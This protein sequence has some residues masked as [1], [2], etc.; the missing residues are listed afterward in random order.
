MPI[1][2]AGGDDPPPMIADIAGGG[3]AVDM[4]LGAAAGD[5]DDDLDRHSRSDSS[6]DRGS[7]SGSADDGETSLGSASDAVDDI[8]A[9]FGEVGLRADPEAED[10]D[11]D[12]GAAGGGDAILRGEEVEGVGSDEPIAAGGGAASS[13]GDAPFV[14]PAPLAELEPAWGRSTCKSSKSC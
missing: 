11:I 5:G 10:V 9:L 6:A 12:D 4:D 3:A 7:G 8:L 14:G 2:D 1:A 13:S